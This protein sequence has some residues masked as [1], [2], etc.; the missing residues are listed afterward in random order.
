LFAIFFLLQSGV[1][2]IYRISLQRQNTGRVFYRPGAFDV[3]HSEWRDSAP[4]GVMPREIVLQDESEVIPAGAG[5]PED[6]LILQM[7]QWEMF[8][9]CCQR[10]RKWNWIRALLNRVNLVQSDATGDPLHVIVLVK[11][12]KSLHVDYTSYLLY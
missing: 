7:S 10:I 1:G 4:N 11:W 8:S 2:S 6:P 3:P 5:S 9:H 12:M